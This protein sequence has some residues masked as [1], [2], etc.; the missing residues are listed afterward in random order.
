MCSFVGIFAKFTEKI[1]Q[2][3]FGYHFVTESFCPVCHLQFSKRFRSPGQCVFRRHRCLP[4]RHGP[5]NCRTVERI[6]TNSDDCEF[7][8]VLVQCQQH[9]S[10]S[11]VLHILPGLVHIHVPDIVFSIRYT[12]DSALTLSTTAPPHCPQYLPNPLYLPNPHY[13]HYLKY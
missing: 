8:R 1:V 4:A 11:G 9:L 10:N 2:G 5:L 13:L 7:G 6:T 12:L 3:T